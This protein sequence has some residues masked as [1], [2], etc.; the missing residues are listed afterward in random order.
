MTVLDLFVTNNAVLK[1]GDFGF[2]LFIVVSWEKEIFD[3]GS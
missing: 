2:L 1:T 3:Y